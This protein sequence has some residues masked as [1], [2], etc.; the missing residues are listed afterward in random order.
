MSQCQ[1]PLSLLPHCDVTP[2]SLVSS[3]DI[4]MSMSPFPVASGDGAMYR[5][6]GS[7]SSYS[8]GRHWDAEEE[9]A[10]AAAAAAVGGG[11]IRRVQERRPPARNHISPV[12]KCLLFSFNFLFWVRVQQGT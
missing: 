4:T 3:C 6:Y 2:L 8:Y 5:G 11:V 12:V 1:Y 7:G 10:A 9:A